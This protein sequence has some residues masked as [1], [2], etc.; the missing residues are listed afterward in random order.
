MNVLT[1]TRECGRSKAIGLVTGLGNISEKGHL[2]CCSSTSPA[3]PSACTS[4]AG[5]RSSTTPPPGN[6][7]RTEFYLCPVKDVWSNRIV[8][9][10]DRLPLEVRLAVVRCTTPPPGAT[11][12]PGA[13][14]TPTAACRADLGSSP[15]RCSMG[16][17]GTAGDNAA[18]ESFFGSLQN[19]AHGGRPW[20]TRDDL[21]TEIVIWIEPTHHRRRCLRQVEPYRVRDHRDTTGAA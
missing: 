20:G 7:S 18:M 9:L 17:G 5:P 6:A 11:A 19:S 12:Q 8:G 10:L 1:R 4:T 13:S 2:E 14:C 15:P 16:R 21:R 3:M